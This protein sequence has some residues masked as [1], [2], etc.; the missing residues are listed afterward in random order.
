[1]ETQ[2]DLYIQLTAVAHVISTH[3]FLAPLFPLSHLLFE[4]ICSL[5]QLLN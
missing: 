3:Q 2:G 1:M 5:G 4:K